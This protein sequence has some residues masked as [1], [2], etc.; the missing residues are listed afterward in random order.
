LAVNADEDQSLVPLFVAREKWDVPTV[1][2]D[3]LGKFLGVNAL[4]TVIILD[5]NGK[6]VYRVAGF[7]EQGF[8]ESLTD[9][10]Q[11]AVKQTN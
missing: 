8:A 7:P 9:A 1:Y 11:A 3:G 2:S 6:I 5:R 10:I 4:P